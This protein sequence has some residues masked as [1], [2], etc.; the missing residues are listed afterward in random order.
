MYVCMSHAVRPCALPRCLPPSTS[1][2]RTGTV[3]RLEAVCADTQQPPRPSA[4]PTKHV[5]ATN[6]PARGPS[7]PLCELTSC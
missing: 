5:E 7:L 6:H 1:N 2:P 4:A 3:N